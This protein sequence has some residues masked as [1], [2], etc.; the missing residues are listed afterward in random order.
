[1]NPFFRSARN[2][3]TG[4]LLCAGMIALLAHAAASPPPARTAAPASKYNSYVS[5]D[6]SNTNP[7]TEIS[8][9]LTIQH[10]AS[11]AVPGTTIHV[12]KG[13]YAGGITT[14]IS[15]DAFNRISYISTEKW[16]ARIVPPLRSS[17]H[18]AWDNR[19]SYVD[20]VGFDIDGSA[21]EVGTK[22]LHGIYNGGSKT[23]IR[24][25]HVH[26][27]A[28][29]SGCGG[30]GSSGIG[31]DSYYRGSH[32]DA[33]GNH[34]HDIGP[35]GCR[36]NKGIYL[37]TTG[38]VM[39]NVVYNIGGTGI[40]LWHDATR[41]VIANNTVVASTSG[42]VI[43]AGD[44]YHTKGPND[45][46]SVYNNIVYDNKFGISENGWTGKNNSYRNNLV[47]QNPGFNWELRNNLKHSG[48]VTAP[49]KFVRY[50]KTGKP[51]FRLQ[52]TSP[53]VGMG[54]APPSQQ[55]DLGGKPREK[56]RAIDIGAFQH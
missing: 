3:C 7:G 21:S 6:G 25:N 26:H 19:G 49:P 20:I 52:V 38:R 48:T 10:A 53:G 44:Y 40:Q 1:M 23:S 42:I 9:Y 56:G 11:M 50:S 16:G 8:P 45:H 55:L 46:T 37:N 32:S 2:I 36:Y 43:G 35:P 15:G 17:T 22:W 12:A 30:G 13:T 51:D 28:I 27:I 39:N 47:A 4:T 34:V 14:T 31:V 54:L 18:T 29:K 33:V 24:D 5:P 41:A